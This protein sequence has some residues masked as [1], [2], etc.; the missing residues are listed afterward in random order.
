MKPIELLTKELNVW[1][2]CKQK[3]KISYEKGDID[4]ELHKIHLKNLEPKI[5]EYKIAIQI[6]NNYLK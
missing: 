6:L 1:K 3:S 2:R 4:L 5:K